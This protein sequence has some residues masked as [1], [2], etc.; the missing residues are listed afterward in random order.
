[1]YTCKCWTVDT[2]HFTIELEIYHSTTCIFAPKSWIW[3]KQT[4]TPFWIGMYFFHKDN[5]TGCVSVTSGVSVCKLQLVVFWLEY[6]E[7]ID[8]LVLPLKSLKHFYTSSD[9]PW[10]KQNMSFFNRFNL[11][12]P[13]HKH[14]CFIYSMIHFYKYKPNCV[15]MCV[16]FFVFLVFLKYIVYIYQ[17]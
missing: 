9:L 8:L 7:K 4:L 10:N 2:P 6:I 5:A 11:N 1:M 3:W 12:L 13:V 14:I 17:K 16:W 15:R